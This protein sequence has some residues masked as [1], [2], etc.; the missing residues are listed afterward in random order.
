MPTQLVAAMLK[1]LLLLPVALM[2][3][4]E[5]SDSTQVFAQEHQVSQL[6]ADI[7]KLNV[8]RSSGNM[9]A[10]RAQIDLDSEKWRSSDRNA[11]LIYMYRA[12]IC[13][14]HAAS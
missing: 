2:C 4:I 13:I 11:F 12:C 5:L 3:F 1:R 8:L 6:D 10:L 14:V 9:D 7:A